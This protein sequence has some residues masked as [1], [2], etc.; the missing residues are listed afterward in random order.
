MSYYH[1]KNI[2]IDKKK[3][4]ISADLADSSLYP[5][6]FYN[7]EFLCQRNTF[8]E[9]YAEFIYNLVSGNFHPTSNSKY[10][11]L[12]LNN[13][14]DNYYEDA[15][16]IGVVETYKKYKDNVDAILSGNLSK[17]KHIESD[18][19]LHPE[20]YYL[21]TKLDLDTGYNYDYYINRK[22]KLYTFVNNKIMCCS[23]SEKNFGYPLSTVY[24]K[25][26]EKLLEYNDFLKENKEVEPKDLNIKDLI[27][28]LTESQTI[29]NYAFAGF[30]TETEQK[31]NEVNT[32]I[33][34]HDILIK[35]RIQLAPNEAK[36][37]KEKVK[38]KVKKICEDNNLKYSEMRSRIFPRIYDAINNKYAVATYRELPSFYFKEILQDIETLTINVADLIDQVA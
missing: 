28:S 37:V 34:E 3:N 12:V 17:I 22:G 33:D 19:E 26:K 31:F 10:S 18:K 38:E 20:K 32:R 25:E 4:N 16:D 2:N 6:T 27:K 29:M 5:L 21:L 15:K 11:K 23:Q 7:S 24:G 14:L 9:T 30:K 13:Y 36:I 35:K 8:E 1:I